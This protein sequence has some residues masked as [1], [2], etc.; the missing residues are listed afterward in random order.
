MT[1]AQLIGSGGIIDSAI[2]A[3]SLLNAPSLAVTVDGSGGGLHST[4]L[5]VSLLLAPF[6]AVTA[7]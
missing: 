5:A 3:V 6:L 7:T 1:V 2:L 4:T